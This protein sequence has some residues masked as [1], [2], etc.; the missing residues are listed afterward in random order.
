MEGA[1]LNS[2]DDQKL[3][4]LELKISFFLRYGVF[5][6]AAFLFVG[7]MG[8]IFQSSDRLS[9]FQIYRPEPL[10]MIIQKALSLSDYPMLSAVLGLAILVSLP[11]I[12]VFLTAYL[13]IQSKD[14][15]LAAMALFVSAILCLSFFLGIEH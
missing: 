15:Y 11:I 12:R 14:W 7:W 3:S 9:H 8:Q 10:E 1:P 5:V 4:R 2:S 13:F 6:S